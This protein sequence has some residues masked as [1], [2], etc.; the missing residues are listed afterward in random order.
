MPAGR[1][2]FEPTEQQRRMV[3]SLAGCGTTQDAI[4]RIMEIDSKTLRKH[5]RRELDC[6]EDKANAQVANTGFKMAVSGKFPIMTKFWLQARNGWKESSR[7]YAIDEEHPLSIAAA[8][9]AIAEATLSRPKE[10]E[11]EEPITS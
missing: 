4:A 11:D 1:K 8:R 3:E 5:F 7:Q 10:D 9:A 2:N 6:G